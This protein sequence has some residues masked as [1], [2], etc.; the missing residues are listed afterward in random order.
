MQNSKDYP[1]S[2][3][4]LSFHQVVWQDSRYYWPGLLSSGGDIVSGCLADDMFNI[5]ITT[6]VAVIP[7]VWAFPH[8]YMLKVA[9]NRCLQCIFST[10]SKEVPY[11]V[12][13]NPFPCLIT[14]NVKCSDDVLLINC[15]YICIYAFN[16]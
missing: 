12:R 13:N 14:L 9:K 3:L 2:L 7:F 1:R 6:S 8:F 4:H 16:K 10:A 5:Q 15:I 11:F